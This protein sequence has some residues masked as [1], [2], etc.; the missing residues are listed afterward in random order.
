MV[1]LRTIDFA[2]RVCLLLK[3]RRR[4]VK[5]RRRADDRNI[6]VNDVKISI[7]HLI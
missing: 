3:D 2:A 7:R 4:A 5:D 1:L 6:H